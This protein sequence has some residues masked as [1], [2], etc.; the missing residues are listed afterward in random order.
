MDAPALGRSLHAALQQVPDPRSRQGQRHPL[1]AVVTVMTVALLS[2][3]R[4]VYAIAHWGRRQSPD[5]V[6]ALGFARGRP[7]AVS[8]LHEV[9]RRLDPT[10]LETVV[11]HWAQGD[12]VAA[13]S[14]I[15]LDGKVAARP[16]WP[17]RAA[18]HL[19][20][21]GGSVHA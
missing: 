13:G 11:A 2:G 20:R 15:A 17:R 12:D 10:A 19:D 18:Q 6:T 9:T 4:S 5:G 1:S 3:A 14:G 8:T 21:C 7:P 16:S